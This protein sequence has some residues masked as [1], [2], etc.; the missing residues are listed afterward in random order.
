[1]VATILSAQCTDERV[2][3]VTPELFKRFSTPYEMSRAGVEEIELLIRSINFF[4]NKARAI[5]ETSQIL[6]DQFQ[7]QV[8]ADL[9]Q[10]TRLRGVGRKTA[11]VVL[12]VA[13]SVPSLVVDTHVG[14]LS[15]RMGFTSHSDP[16]KIEQDLMKILPQE[17]WN[18]YNHLIID[19]GR[20]TCKARK[21][22]CSSCVVSQDCPKI[23]VT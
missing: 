9:D 1:M 10:L 13:F 3:Q 14:R 17:D 23:G 8:P 6:V 21:A 19:H 18:I 15:R 4:R 16:A 5:H 12:G 11:N 7:G 22:L 2:N 20:K